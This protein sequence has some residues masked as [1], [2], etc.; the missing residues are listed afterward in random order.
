MDRS[1]W[2]CPDYL[3]LYSRSALIRLAIDSQAVSPSEARELQ[4]LP[5]AEIIGW[6]LESDSLDPTYLPP[7]LAFETP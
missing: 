2:L 5:R 1:L 6:I 3:G 4:E 7:E